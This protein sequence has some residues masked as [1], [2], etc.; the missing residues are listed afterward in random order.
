MSLFPPMP[1]DYQQLTKAEIVARFQS[2]QR[3]RVFVQLLRLYE[4][5]P[6]TVFQGEL[7]LSLVW[8]NAGPGR[9]RRLQPAGTPLRLILISVASDGPIGWAE[10]SEDDI[11]ESGDVVV[12]DYLM[13]V[14]SPSRSDPAPIAQP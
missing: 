11:G 14:Y 13:R 1:Q 3:P 12:E 6:V 10:G 5:E 8:S 7:E 4:P 2:Q 9:T